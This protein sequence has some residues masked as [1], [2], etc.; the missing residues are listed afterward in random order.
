MSCDK[1]ISKNVKP[2]LTRAATLYGL[3]AGALR[4]SHHLWHNSAKDACAF[5]KVFVLMYEVRVEWN[6]FLNNAPTSPDYVWPTSMT[7]PYLAI[8]IFVSRAYISIHQNIYI[9]FS[10]ILT[11]P[12]VLLRYQ[13]WKLITYVVL[14]GLRRG[15][16]AYVGVGGSWNASMVDDSS[17][18][19]R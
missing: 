6:I 10:G 4:R 16:T 7:D 9:T 3:E 17:H 2:K 1:S 19:S 13:V 8:D 14:D 15:V 12:S 18:L 5:P 11:C